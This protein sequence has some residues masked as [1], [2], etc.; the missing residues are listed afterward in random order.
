MAFDFWEA[1]ND[2]I[3]KIGVSSMVVSSENTSNGTQDDNKRTETNA[4]MGA[5][6]KKKADK[7]IE[8]AG[9]LEEKLLAKS[10]ACRTPGKKIKSK[11]KGR[12][13]AIG[14]GNGPIGRMRYVK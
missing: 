11:G 1:F 5:K 8:S 10:A 2:E 9:F 12:G 6:D 4:S 7:P 14:K 13:L 3:T